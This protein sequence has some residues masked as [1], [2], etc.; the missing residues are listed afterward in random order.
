MQIL[1]DMQVILSNRGFSHRDLF[2]IGEKIPKGSF[3]AAAAQMRP[4]APHSMH[5]SAAMT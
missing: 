2:T 1:Q 4:Q 5:R 3:T